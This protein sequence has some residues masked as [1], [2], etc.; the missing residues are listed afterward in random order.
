MRR[1]IPLLLILATL[2]GAQDRPAAHG[3]W[4]HILFRVSEAA[5]AA[6]NGADAYSS[7]GRY[8]SNPVLGRGQFGGGQ[9]AIKTAIVGGILLGQE[10][11][12]RKLPA[13]APAFTVSN[14][15]VAGYLG[16]QARRNL[17][18]PTSNQSTSSTR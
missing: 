14:F 7:L 2:A 11:A 17:G 10:I 3:K 13:M 8:E 18:I 12:A 4:K 16:W 15:G 9:I 1:L 6:G 5:L